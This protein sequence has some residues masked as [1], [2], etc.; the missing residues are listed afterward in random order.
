[1]IDRICGLEHEELM[2]MVAGYI[3]TGRFHQM[4]GLPAIH[5][6]LIVSIKI[7]SQQS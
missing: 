5:P 3:C 2:A 7:R 4:F 1:M 6:A